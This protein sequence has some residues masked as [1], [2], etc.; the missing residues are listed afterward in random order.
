MI[1]RGGMM[2]IKRRK[3]GNVMLPYPLLKKS[4]YAIWS[5]KMGVNLQTQGVWDALSMVT[6]LRSVRTG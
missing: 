4:N 3:E 5:I 1:K 6:T 2:M